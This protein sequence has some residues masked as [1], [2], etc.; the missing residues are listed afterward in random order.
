MATEKSDVYDVIIVGAGISGI[1]A[2]YRVQSELPGSKYALL[3][4]RGGMGGTWD[5]FKYPGLRSDS[6]LHTFGFP[7]RPWTEQKA[8]AEGPLIKKY[9]IET[10]ESEGIDKHILYHHKLVS[11][12]W[13]SSEQNWQLTVDVDGKK[14]IFRS[15]FIILGTGYYDYDEAL[16]ATIPGIQ[17]FKGTIVHPQF[18]PEDLDYEHK[19]IVVIGSGATAVT[20]LPNLAQKAD[21]VT[22]LQR[23]PGYL[24][25]QPAINPISAFVKKWFPTSISYPFVRAQFLIVPYMFFLFCRAYPTIAKAILRKRTSD[26]LP[27]NVPHDPHFKPTYNPWEQRL[28]LCPDG[29]FFAALRSGKTDIATGHIEDMTDNTIVLKSGQ[30]LT[31]DILV[32]ATG[33]KISMA[34]GSSVSV[35]GEPVVIGSKFLWK[36]MMLQDVPNAAFVIGYTNASWTLGADATAL[37]V[38]RLIKNMRSQGASVATPRLENSAAMKAQPT[39]NLNSTYV[40]KAADKMPKAG[41][42]GPWKPRTNYFRDSWNAKYGNL[43]DGLEFLRPVST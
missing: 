42:E 1:N 16:P 8:I 30:E 36:G 39:L 2:A 13:S 14:Q 17:N 10:A 4:A 40:M 5:F 22:M 28:C 12:N 43:S 20:L 23:S 24:I 7:W 29:D 37:S 9:V 26:Q 21:H 18:W 19:K 41:T 15:K 34:G 3:E 27:K 38:T 25:S 35:D 32:T 31:A 6:D 33:L 11:S